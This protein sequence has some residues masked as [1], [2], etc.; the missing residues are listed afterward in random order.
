MR[1]LSVIITFVGFLFAAT[2]FSST[3]ETVT[4]YNMNGYSFT[5]GI[6]EEAQLTR[7]TTM[8]VTDGRI[9]ATGDHGLRQLVEANREIDFHGKTVLPG[10][11]DAHG[12]I[13]GLGQN[14]NE[15]DLRGINSKA[16][17]VA[18]VANYA[19]QNLDL[20]WIIGRGWNQVLWPENAF[21][22][23]QDIDNVISDR[24]VWLT[25]IDGHAGWANSAALE[26]AG[27]TAETQSPDGG[28]IVK[29][30]NGNPTGIL[31]DTAMELLTQHIPG[32]SEQSIRSNYHAAFDQLLSLGITQVHDA[33][34]DARH[35]NIYQQLL[36]E[37]ALPIRVH[38][39]IAGNSPN[40]EALLEQG[41]S[42]DEFD[43]LQINSVKLYGDG[44]LG[45][46]GA[47]LIH[48]YSDDPDNSGLLVTPEERVYQLFSTIHNAGFQVNYHAIGDYSNRLALD[49]FAQLEQE[50]EAPLAEMR[51][52]IEH[53]QIV[54]VEDIPRFKTLGIIPSM[55]PTHATSDMNMAE[56][57]VGTERIA[58]AYAWR[59]F[60]DQGSI[61]AAGSD[62]PVELANPFYG[63]HAA[64]T[65][66]DRD[67]QPVEG[68]HPE[69]RMSVEEAIR[70]FTIDAA[71]A[72]HFDDDTGSLEPGKWADFIVINKD[73]FTIAP[74]H[75]WKIDVL[76][77][78][79][80]GERQ[81]KK[82]H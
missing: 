49:T 61:I 18:Q 26:L 24:P 20:D 67:N 11:I 48:P 58:G 6:G 63:I 77:T 14:L 31:I 8:V 76:A 65:R 81:Y 22:N 32:A 40:L 23:R 82:Q 53:A 10:I 28:E 35:L 66:Q 73:P 12:H 42:R 71:F 2:S 41:T 78:Y 70:S 59:T 17:S 30:E 29:D 34:A 15:V 21:P 1:P 80:A 51:H 43:R 4:Y 9:V 62:F 50:H 64:V 44:A 79:V 36:S 75:L 33:G 54:Q 47:A 68:W 57:R 72:G 69:Q 13:Q 45:S 27:I 5:Q 60:L 25:R 16:S 46:R 7:F 19:D 39:M 74:E 37:G 3:A 55:Q 52:R 38:A 56:D